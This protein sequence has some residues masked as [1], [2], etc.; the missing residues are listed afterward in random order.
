MENCR[1]I[2]IHYESLSLYDKTRCNLKSL[3]LSLNAYCRYG[4]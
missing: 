4:V 3:Q 1:K 2:T